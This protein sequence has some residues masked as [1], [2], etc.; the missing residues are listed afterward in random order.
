MYKE[1]EVVLTREELEL[2]Y[3]VCSKSNAEE[4]GISVETGLSQLAVRKAIVNGNHLIV[5]WNDDT[6]T[7]TTC[8]EGDEF[9]PYYG[10]MA[11]FMKKILGSQTFHAKM[12]RAMKKIETHKA[13]VKTNKT[14]SKAKKPA[15][16]SA[17]KPTSTKK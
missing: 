11:A 17:K 16:K 5:L 8:A 12:E 9:N 2:M 13:P 6:K 15:S 4:V 1:L 10:I 14:D 7:V 3:S